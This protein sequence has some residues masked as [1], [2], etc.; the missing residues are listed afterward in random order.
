[1]AEHLPEEHRRDVHPDLLIIGRELLIPELEGRP[2]SLTKVDSARISQ[3]YYL[4]YRAYKKYHP[5]KADAYLRVAEKFS[6]T[7]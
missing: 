7:R 4:A 2:Y 6:T 3:G 5:D 1:M